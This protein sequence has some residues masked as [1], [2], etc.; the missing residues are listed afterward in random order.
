[1]FACSKE[2]LLSHSATAPARTWHIGTSK[3]NCAHPH[4]CDSAWFTKPATIVRGRIRTRAPV[5][6]RKLVLLCL[7]RAVFFDYVFIL[8]YLCLRFAMAATLLCSVRYFTA[9]LLGYIFSLLLLCL[10]MSLLCYVSFWRCV[11][12]A[13]VDARRFHAST[14]FPRSTQLQEGGSLSTGFFGIKMAKS[15]TKAYITQIPKQTTSSHIRCVPPPPPQTATFL[16]ASISTKVKRVPS[17]I[18]HA[19]ITSGDSCFDTPPT[20]W[21]EVDVVDP[22][23]NEVLQLGGSPKF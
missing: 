7:C 9:S 12:F 1:M 17:E 10:A 3:T 5:M 2:N 13:S 11:Y 6:L 15:S 8:P 23:Y 19:E 16:L 20:K 21:S 22:Q 4:A 14:A 18:Q